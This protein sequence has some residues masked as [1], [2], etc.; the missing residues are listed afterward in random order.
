MRAYQERPDL[1]LL[2]I[3][4]PKMD[5]MTVLKKLRA[6]PWGK[7]VSVVFLTNLSADVAAHK[8]GFAEKDMEH[9]LVKSDYSIDE[10]VSKVKSVVS[11]KK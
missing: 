8:N 10:V 1:V 4:M 11:K 9:F 5:G 6:D 3:V 7:T 2:D